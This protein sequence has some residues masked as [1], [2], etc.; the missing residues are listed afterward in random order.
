MSLE[1][2]VGRCPGAACSTRVGK[3][4]I[5]STLRKQP[6]G[7]KHPLY[8][9]ISVCIRTEHDPTIQSKSH[10]TADHGVTVLVPALEQDLVKLPCSIILVVLAGSPQG[11]RA[12]VWGGKGDKPTCMGA[13]ACAGSSAAMPS[14]SPVVACA[15]R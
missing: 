10:S 9:A 4:G 8:E 11:Q 6:V 13:A 12:K 7:S 1:V 2:A 3:S 14:G 15:T 5:S